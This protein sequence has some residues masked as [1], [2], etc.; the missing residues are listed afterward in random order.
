MVFRSSWQG[1]QVNEEKSLYG[2]ASSIQVQNV[3]N[4]VRVEENE[5]ELCICIWSMWLLG[6]EMPC[7]VWLFCWAP[8]AARTWFLTWSKVVMLD[9]MCIQNSFWDWREVQRTDVLS[10]IERR[11]KKCEFESGK[12]RE[13]RWGENESMS[14]LRRLLYM[15]SSDTLAHILIIDAQ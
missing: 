2:R 13:N 3:R 1:W 14:K 5:I 10:N 7:V 6:L 12:M 8:F 4:E 9:A 11:S 15:C